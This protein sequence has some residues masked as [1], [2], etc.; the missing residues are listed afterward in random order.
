M[1][2]P[3]WMM[4]EFSPWIRFLSAA[5]AVFGA[6]SLSVQCS[7]QV[8]RRHVK[9]AVFRVHFLE[10]FHSPWSNNSLSGP[11]LESLFPSMET[12]Q[13]WL[14]RLCWYIWLCTDGSVNIDSGEP[15]IEVP[16]WRN[17]NISSMLI[18]D[19]VVLCRQSGLAYRHC[20]TTWLSLV[21]LL[22]SR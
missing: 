13:A 2:Y 1:A 12:K 18:V 8:S 22:T 9:I 19:F 4:N 7:R 17:T 21:C 3:P 6:G 10:N 20:G 14:L 15:T 16:S 5:A 11:P